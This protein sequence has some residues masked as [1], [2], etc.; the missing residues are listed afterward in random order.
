MTGLYLFCLIVGLPLLLWMAI[1]GDADGGD[2][3]SLDLDG[4]GPFVAIP[5][6][7]IAFFLA[8][9]GAIGLIGEW[10][11]TPLLVTLLA[12]GAIGIG[13]GWGSKALLTWAGADDASSTVADH[14]L[15]GTIAQV[16]LPVSSEHRG[17][18]ILDIAGAREQMTASPADGSTIDAGER[19]VVVRIEGGVALVAPLGPLMELE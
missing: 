3:L 5:L 18:I 10:T 11:D 6:S 4:D 1:G 17:K 8:G 9:F 2:G 19:V 13:A 14:E 15:E 16:A 7:A 12:A